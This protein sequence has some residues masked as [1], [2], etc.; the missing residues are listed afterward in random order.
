[1]NPGRL[2]AGSHGGYSRPMSKF[3]P[4]RPGARGL[5]ICASGFTLIEML[6]VIGIIA[7][8]AA[9]LIPVT[10][11]ALRQARK[12]ACMSNTH[13]MALAAIVLF[14]ELENDLPNLDASC[15]AYGAAAN[16]LLPYVK[17]EARVF[18]CPVNNPTILKNNSTEIPGLANTYNEYVINAYLASCDGAIRKQ[19]AIVDPDK[20]AYVW[21]N[22]WEP[23]EPDR[24]H[25]DGVNCAYLDGHAAWLADEDMGNLSNPTDPDDPAFHSAGHEFAALYGRIY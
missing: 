7:T 16:V 12:S 24:A 4:I 13:Q 25:D 19:S 5:G 14:S 17:Q 11:N 15:T 22:P 18:D 10:N 2:T 21:D 1:L 23:N 8:L 20:V 6:V 3:K 9:I